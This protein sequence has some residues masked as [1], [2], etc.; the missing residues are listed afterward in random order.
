M[1]PSLLS[2]LARFN[3]DPKQARDYC[4]IMALTYPALTEEYQ[5][6]AQMLD[7]KTLG[8]NKQMHLGDF[9]EKEEAALAYNAAAREHFG[10]FAR[11]NEVRL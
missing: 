1:N 7:I 9:T 5:G 4:T 3:G 8:A 11:L 2:I 10:E 6:Y